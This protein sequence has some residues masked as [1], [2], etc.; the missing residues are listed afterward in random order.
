MEQSGTFSSENDV[1]IKKIVEEIQSRGLEVPAI[2]LFET[3]RPLGNLLM[4]L[5]FFF[6]LF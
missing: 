3:Y 5:V 1:L 4:H 6:R 2:A